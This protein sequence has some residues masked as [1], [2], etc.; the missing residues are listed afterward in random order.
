[1]A[2]CLERELKTEGEAGIGTPPVP[3]CRKLDASPVSGGRPGARPGRTTCSRSMSAALRAPAA[4]SP[5]ASAGLSVGAGRDWK[6][7][8]PPLPSRMM[9]C[10]A[11]ERLETGAANGRP[12]LLPALKAPPADGGREEGAGLACMADPKSVLLE[13]CETPDLLCSGMLVGS[14]Y[15]PPSGLPCRC[16]WD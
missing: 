11:A 9:R 1:M 7:S 2:A 5:D 12:E 6:S 15:L 4:G 16:R 14:L 3:S 8:T 10:S 13:P